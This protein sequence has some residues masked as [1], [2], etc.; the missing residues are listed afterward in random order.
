M[1]AIWNK[2]PPSPKS[3]DRPPALARVG[4]THTHFGSWEC[5][6]YGISHKP[7]SSPLQD[8]VFAAHPAICARFYR[9]HRRGTEIG[10]STYS[11]RHKW[12]QLWLET[13]RWTPP[14]RSSRFH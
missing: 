12:R 7:K 14:F 9:R 10:V 2:Y 4:V 8:P 11:H 5:H 13:P 3:L 6:S 1:V